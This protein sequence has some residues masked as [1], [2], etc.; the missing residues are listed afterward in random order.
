M[1]RLVEVAPE[2]LADCRIELLGLVGSAARNDLSKRSDI[3]V[4]YRRQPDA[5]VTLLDVSRAQRRLETVFSR[6]V[7]LIDWSA[8]KTHYKSSMQKDFHSLYG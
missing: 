4:A 2:I 7:D 5:R 1:H 8:V 6:K 3:D